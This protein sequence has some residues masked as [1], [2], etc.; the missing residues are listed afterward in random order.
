MRPTSIADSPVWLVVSGTQLVF[1]DLVILIYGEDLMDE[2]DLRDHRSS[3]RTLEARGDFA[4]SRGAVRG[5]SGDSG[6]TGLL[7]LPQHSRLSQ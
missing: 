7:G 4:S 3:H 2:E 5:S 1:V 6:S